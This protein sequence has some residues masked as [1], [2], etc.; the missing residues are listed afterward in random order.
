MGSHPIQLNGIN[1]S[2]GLWL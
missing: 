1:C 2:L